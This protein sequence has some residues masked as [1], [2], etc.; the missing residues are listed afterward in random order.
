MTY[1]TR[2]AAYPTELGQTIEKVF[3]EGQ[4][5]TIHFD[6]AQTAHQMRGTFYAFVRAL[7][8]SKEPRHQELFGKG[9]ALTFR[10]EG[11]ALIVIHKGH[12]TAIRTLAEA[13]NQEEGNANNSLE[14][15]KS[16]IGNADNAG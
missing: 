10:I 11:N 9:V 7:G 14:R 5:M 1:P 8:K 15:L 12:T 3:D 13:L 16:K 2:P 4:A 6:R